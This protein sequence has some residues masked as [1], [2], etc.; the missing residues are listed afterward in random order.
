MTTQS[1]Q[2]D[3]DQLMQDHD[4][5]IL[6]SYLTEPEAE[7][8]EPESDLTE[9]EAHLIMPATVQPAFADPMANPVGA[10]EPGDREPVTPV[11]SAYPGFTADEGAVEPGIA[12]RSA[13]S[14]AQVS[15]AD[16]ATAS[17]AESPHADQ[18][19]SA[20]GPWSEIQAIFVDDPRASIE[21]AAG[22]VDDRV[23]ALISA[24]RDEQDSLKS[25]WQYDSTGTEE[26]RVALQR[27]RAFWSRLEDL[28][29][30]D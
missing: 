24:V 16:V 25:A 3:D 28:A 15:V 14:P 6:A 23:E 29:R 19:A 12:A 5:V 17:A 4:Q 27:Y 26:L 18:A 11:V 2:A 8:I 9:P 22:L 7:L 13:G 10:E 1:H 20:G 21:L 30:Q